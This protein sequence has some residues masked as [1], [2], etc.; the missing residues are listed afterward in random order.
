MKEGKGVPK[1]GSPSLYESW[2]LGQLGRKFFCWR[3]RWVFFVGVRIGRAWSF[4]GA[5][6]ATV[7]AKREAWP[8][9]TGVGLL[10][11]R[12]FFC[13][14]AT[15]VSYADVGIERAWSFT[16]A[17]EAIVMAKREAW[18][19]GDAAVTMDWRRCSCAGER[20]KKCEFMFYEQVGELNPETGAG[21]K[22]FKGKMVF[23]SFGE[24]SK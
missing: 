1:R 3:A 24:V 10:W 22:F 16:R 20:E 7:M 14:R 23:L 8:C 4:A 11:G 21:V 5:L 9:G 6:E 13:W 19:E 2:D 15:W 17:L 18:I 12:K